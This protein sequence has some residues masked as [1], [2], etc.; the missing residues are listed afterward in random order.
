MISYTIEVKVVGFLLCCF[1]L[2]QIVLF[3]VRLYTGWLFIDQIHWEGE[4]P[5][6]A[7]VGRLVL[8]VAGKVRTVGSRFTPWE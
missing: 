4:E 2:S 3:F 8:K 6:K 1:V 5:I 7:P